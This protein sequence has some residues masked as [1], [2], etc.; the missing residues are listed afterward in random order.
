MAFFF[1]KNAHYFLWTLGFICTLTYF[2]G[3]A[4]ACHCWLGSGWVH[5]LGG[6]GSGV[7]GWGD[8]GGDVWLWDFGVEVILD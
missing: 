2:V 1:Q 7:G 4:G 3:L 6:G 5:V 8:W